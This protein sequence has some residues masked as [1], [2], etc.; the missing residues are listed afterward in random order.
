M[1][2]ILTGDACAVWLDGEIADPAALGD[3]L[4]P[5]PPEAMV[6]DPVGMLVNNVRNNSPECIQRVA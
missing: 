5:Y 6:C 1:P 4:K 3:L 2:V